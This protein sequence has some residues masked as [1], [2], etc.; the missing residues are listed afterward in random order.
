MGFFLENGVS[1]LKKTTLAVLGLTLSGVALA[2]TMGCQPGNVTVPCED[3]KWDL[4]AQALYLRATHTGDKVY[5][6]AQ[7]NGYYPEDKNDWGWGFII[8]GSYHYKTGE[9]ITMNWTHYDNDT[10]QGSISGTALVFQNPA[11]GPTLPGAVTYKVTSNNLFDQVNLVKGQHVDA[12]LLKNIRFYA[13]LQYAKIRYEADN[14]Y[15]T[16]TTNFPQYLNR[17]A[18]YE[19]V[20]PIAG[21]NYGYELAKGFSITADAD[22]SIV[23]GNGRYNSQYVVLFNNSDVVYVNNRYS[24]KYVVP[25]LEAKIGVN[26]AKEMAAGT[27]NIQAG[28]RILNYFNALHTLGENALPIAAGGNGLTSYDFALNGPYIGAKWVGQA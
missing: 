18:Q 13:G 1:M 23:Y 20:G 7:N 16:N 25:S 24:N 9:D 2:G 4:G 3:K 28:F 12:G 11:V 5:H 21:I 14:N 15:S 10:E 22:A 17:Y 8:E 27:L 26:Y 19:G 6:P